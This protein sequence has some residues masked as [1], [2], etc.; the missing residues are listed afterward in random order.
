MN[1][2][3]SFVNTDLNW[4]FRI[5]ALSRLSENSRPPLLRGET[6]TE[7]CLC[8]LMYFQNGFESPLSRL[9]CRVA[10]VSPRWHVFLPDGPA[11]RGRS[12][13]ASNLTVTCDQKHRGEPL[14]LI[15]VD[16][17]GPAALDQLT[18]DQPAYLLQCLVILQAK[19]NINLICDVGHT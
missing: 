4:V 2:E 10:R 1:E 5:S 8:D 11:D 6:P 18:P 12:F 3:S 14:L 17:F 19:G 15:K 7:S 13:L 16:L 9:S